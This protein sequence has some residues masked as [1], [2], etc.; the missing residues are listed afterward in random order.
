MKGWL[1]WIVCAALLAACGQVR[2]VGRP[3]EGRADDPPP[4]AASQPPKAKAPVKAAPGRPPVPDT[5]EKLLDEGGARRIREALAGKGYLDH[6]KASGDLDGST[7]DALRRFQRDEGI[8][9]TG[10]PDR[11]T[12]R[13]LGLDPQEI[14]RTARDDP[15]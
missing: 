11:E 3:E 9:S 5:P 13:R 7:S 12:L 1:S 14:Y 2:R 4:E 10:F 6:G 15:K 8:A